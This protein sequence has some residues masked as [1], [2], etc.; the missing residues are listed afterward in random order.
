MAEIVP[1]D[2]DSHMGQNVPVYCSLS[3]LAGIRVHPGLPDGSS[4]EAAGAVSVKMNISVDRILQPV[5]ESE[6]HDPLFD[7]R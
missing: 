5:S 6:S 2:Y 1:S 3:D 4:F 7:C